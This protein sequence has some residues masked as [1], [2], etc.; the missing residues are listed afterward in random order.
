MA[1]IYSR[2]SAQLVLP[3]ELRWFLTLGAALWV[4]SV[5]YIVLKLH[6][7]HTANHGIPDVITS[8]PFGD[9]YAFANRLQFVHQP[10]FFKPEWGWNYSAPCIFLYKVLYFFC[11][12]RHGHYIY[13]LLVLVCLLPLLLTMSLALRRRGLSA[14]S[15]WLLLVGTLVMS[16]PIALGVHQGNTDALIWIGAAFAVWAYYRG[17]WWT[18]A[19]AIGIVAAFKIY[20]VLLIGLFFPPKKYLQ[21]IGSVLTF[22][23]VTLASLAYIGPSI[24]AAYRK[25]SGGIKLLSDLGF[26]GQDV[27]WN[28]LTFEHSIVSLI[29]VC[30]VGHLELMRVIFR[31]Y[32]P[33]AGAAM[34]LFFLALIWKMPRLNQVLVIVLAMVL[35]PP[36]SYDYTLEMM[37][38]PWAWLVL[39][40]VSAAAAGR[41]IRGMLPVMFCF[42]L[43]CAPELFIKVHGF[44]AYGQ[45]KTVVMLGMLALAARYPFDGQQPTAMSA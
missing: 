43:V 20:P 22:A 40:C 32:L 18:A 35:L 19:V 27:D 42:A 26:Y 38:I 36:K 30:T 24:P 33:V 4:I 2:R 8:P 13:L 29:R 12:R 25:I 11:L 31:Y 16:W 37:Y 7:D 14:Q 5:S 3:R 10:D 41:K 23:A 44:Y 34:A 1:S 15:T 6:F 28:Y 21:A 9:L 17:M 39:L 45:F